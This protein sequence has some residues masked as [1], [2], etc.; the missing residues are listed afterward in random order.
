[1]KFKVRLR[2]LGRNE[3]GGGGK[4]MA[5]RDPSTG[6]VFKPSYCDVASPLNTQKNYKLNGI[7]YAKEIGT[8]TEVKIEFGRGLRRRWSRAVC[9]DHGRERL[10]MDNDKAARI[11]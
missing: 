10:C 9:V 8:I 2:N 3:G 11:G 7:K 4:E 5:G 6:E 1:M